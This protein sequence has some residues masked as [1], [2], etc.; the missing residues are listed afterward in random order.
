MKRTLAAL[1]LVSA[2]GAANAAVLYD[3]I[4]GPYA[5]YPA[6]SGLLG[7]DD[8]TMN[9]ALP[10]ANLTVVKF[11]GGVDVVNKPLYF[12]F[13]KSDG[14]TYVNGF[15]VL[16]PAAGNYIWTI[17]LGGSFLVDSSGI[18][19]VFTDSTDTSYKGQW[20][21]TQTSPAVGSN[22]LNTGYAP[23]PYM[24]AFAF[25]GD[26]VP[27]PASM[28]ALGAGLAAVAARRRRKA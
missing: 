22:D 2:F 13:Y 10:Q 7:W 26:P 5:S 3:S 20:F 18:M 17:T 6:A 24:Q 23:S 14:V 12:D 4:A 9:T 15:S 25:E 16:L 19:A 1:A 28:I 21:L 8:Y 27:E 11:V